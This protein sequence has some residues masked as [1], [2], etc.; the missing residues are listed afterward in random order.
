MRS[1]S[2]QILTIF[3]ENYIENFGKISKL[4]I[5]DQNSLEINPKID[6]IQLKTCKSEQNEVIVF[7]ATAFAK[8]CENF[9]AK[10]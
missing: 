1:K 2:D 9:F 6:K 3:K 5:I 8:R 7:F 4:A 10:V